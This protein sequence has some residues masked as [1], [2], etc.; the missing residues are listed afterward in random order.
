M[1][2][3]ETSEVD[4]DDIVLHSIDPVPVASLRPGRGF[5]QVF[6]PSRSTPLEG[7]EAPDAQIPRAALWAMKYRWH[8]RWGGSR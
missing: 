8:L 2:D 3:E 6:V 4:I 7:D 1:T 5:A